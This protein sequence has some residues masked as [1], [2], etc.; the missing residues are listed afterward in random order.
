MI[1]V[2]G[3]A[4][5]IG[6]CFVHRLN[7]LQIDDVLIVDDVGDGVK[8]KNLRGLNFEAIF[9]I[10]K[11]KEALSLYQS[12]ITA[13]IHMGACSSTTEKNVDYLLEN[14]TRQS[15]DYAQFCARNQIPFIY[16]SSAAT[17]GMGEFGFSDEHEQIKKLLPINP[18][19]YS[20]HQFDLWMLKNF[21]QPHFFWAGL[22]FFNVYGPQEYHKESQASVVFHAFNQ[23]NQSGRVRLF[24]SHKDGVADGEQE[25][26]FVHVMDAVN[27]G[28]NLLN[29]KHSPQN[30]G[31]YNIGTGKARSF[32]DLVKTVFKALGREVKIDWIETP[33]ELRSQYQYFTQADNRKIVDLLGDSVKYSSLESGVSSYVSEFLVNSHSYLRPRQ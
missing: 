15:T 21:S 22:K 25:R 30:S 24:K 33:V 8:W 16:A 2:T 29:F 14:N 18:Y 23:I 13:V 32:L 12:K 31:V 20:K 3:G 6:S 10:A 17:Y 1:L 19:G 27:M 11:R 7:Q 5:F 26:D 28:L 4:G 9:P